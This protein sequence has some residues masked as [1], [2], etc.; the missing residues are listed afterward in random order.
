MTSRLRRL[1][2][3]VPVALLC[4]HFGTSCTSALAEQVSRP[5]GGPLAAAMAEWRQARAATKS[6]RV[7]TKGSTTCL[8]G[9]D[10]TVRGKDGREMDFPSR[11]ISYEMENDFYF[12]FMSGKFRHDLSTFALVNPTEQLNPIRKVTI[13]DAVRRELYTANPDR[14]IGRVAPDV[15]LRAKN[16]SDAT[17]IAVCIEPVM[18]THGFLAPSADDG[19][20]WQREPA[21]ADFVL[22]D[23]SPLRLRKALPYRDGMSY[24]ELVF[25]DQRQFRL[26]EA[27]W[28]E[29]GEVHRRLSVQYSG[30]SKHPDSWNLTFSY[31]GRVSMQQVFEVEEWDVNCEL[32][33]DTFGIQ[34]DPGM[35]LKNDDGLFRVG[36]DG[37]SLTPITPLEMAR[38]DIPRRQWLLPTVGILAGAACVLAGVWWRMKSGNACAN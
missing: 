4:L 37:K 31:S 11:D 10:G 2:I 22:I 35:A 1:S 20:G 8:R 17:A 26:V 28:I 13:L 30:D 23:S 32:P 36:G 34:V 6:L 29:A 33:A 25:D 14:A 12:D 18:M 5:D 21:A 24:L 7:K 3:T 9:S 19:K 27:T 16:V 38:G 15:S